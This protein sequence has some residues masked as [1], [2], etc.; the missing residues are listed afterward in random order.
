MQ[1]DPECRPPIR[2]H[3]HIL[4][5]PQCHVFFNFLEQQCSG[6][7]CA[8]LWTCI[9]H[10]ILHYTQY[11]TT[12]F[13]CF[14][15]SVPILCAKH[16]GVMCALYI[17]GLPWSPWLPPSCSWTVTFPRLTYKGGRGIRMDDSSSRCPASQSADLWG[18]SSGQETNPP[19]SREMWGRTSPV[20]CK[21]IPHHFHYLC[22]LSVTG[23][24]F[25]ILISRS[26]SP[27]WPNPADT[28]IMV[29]AP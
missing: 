24:I 16:A 22:L 3:R 14:V 19:H 8:P 17:V 4:Y 20:I 15:L 12:R 1:H 9:L 21:K 5:G 28:A 18:E 27:N 26:W 6:Y 13:L 25:F 11:T 7:K 23:K 2:L 10:Y 29:A